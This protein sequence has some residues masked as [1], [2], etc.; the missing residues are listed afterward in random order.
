MNFLDQDVVLRIFLAMT[1]D[2]R[3]ISYNVVDICEIRVHW[4]Q[5]R[6]RGVN[7]LHA[8]LVCMCFAHLK[9]VSWLS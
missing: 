6:L 3:L 2:T 1:V 5:A 7:L 9:L 4:L 8:M